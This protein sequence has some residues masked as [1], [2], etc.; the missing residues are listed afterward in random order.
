MC[1]TLH[2]V[3]QADSGEITDFASF[4]HL[5]SSII[6]ND[7]HKKL[8]AVYSYYNIARTVTLTDLVRDLMVIARDQGADVFNALDLMQNAQ[9]FEEL[10]FGS[11]DG[12]LQFY[13]YNWKC[14]AMEPSKVGIVLL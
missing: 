2:R 11:G 5:P 1:N 14:A 9:I 13:L 4:Y 3:L 8:N 10:K 6:G 7:K 12:F